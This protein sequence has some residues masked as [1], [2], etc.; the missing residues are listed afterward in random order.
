MTYSIKGFL[1]VSPISRF[2]PQNQGFSADRS[3]FTAGACSAE[4]GSGAALCKSTMG[5][6]RGVIEPCRSNHAHRPD[7]AIFLV[8]IGCTTSDD[9][10]EKN[11]LFSDPMKMRTPGP[12]S[13]RSRISSRLSFF[14]RSSN[15][16]RK[17]IQIL[18]TGQT[19]EKVGAPRTISREGLPSSESPAQTASP[20]STDHAKAYRVRYA[21]AP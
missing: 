16:I 8:A 21:L 13:A 2:E 14:S 10:R 15:S 18:R 5:T 19:F 3:G 11:S 9:P 6:M 1:K 4:G 20:R 7:N 12:L 17:P